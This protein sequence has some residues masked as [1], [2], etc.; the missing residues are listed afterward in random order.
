MADEQSQDEKTEEATPRKLD[1]ARSR[2]QVALSQDFVSAMMLLAAGI[3]FLA[4]GQTLLEAIGAMTGDHL[5]ALGAL[6]TGDIDVDEGAQLLG[7]GLRSV[8]TPLLATVA[9]MVVVGLLAG[10]GQI[11]FRIAG[12][13]LEPNL[14]RFDPIQGAKRIVGM[15]G[16]MRLLQAMLKILIIATVLVSAAWLQRGRIYTLTGSELGPWIQGGPSIVAIA[17]IAALVAILIISL[18]DLIYQRFQFSKDQRMSKSDVKRE[19]KQDEG[20]PMVKGRIR[21]IQRELA[22]RRMMQDVPDATVVVTNPTHFA[23]ALR[24]DPV[25]EPWR[26]APVVVAKGMDATAQEIK[27]IAGEADVPLYED[28][29]LARSLYAEAEI[30]EEVPEALYQAVAAVIQFVWQLEGRKTQGEGVG[31]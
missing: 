27:R 21:S 6:G 2:G 8:A 7:A 23:V 3:S 18:I 20:D 24:Y 19:R 31:A 13:A 26:A 30:G 5:R 28:V 1:E 14:Q 11:G 25:A 10:F 17:T 29:P 9:P 22:M 15:R 16:V 12:K 4:G